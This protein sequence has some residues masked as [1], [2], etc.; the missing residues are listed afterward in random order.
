MNENNI[1][2]NNIL[3]L[4]AKRPILIP[5]SNI[6]PSVDKLRLSTN[7]I[8]KNNESKTVPNSPLLSI[9][10][11]L[12]KSPSIPVMIVDKFDTKEVIET[13][14]ACRPEGEK[15]RPMSPVPIKL[16]KSRENSPDSKNSLLHNNILSDVLLHEIHNIT[17]TNIVT[18]SP[19]TSPTL[20]IRAISPYTLLSPESKKN[21]DNLVER[22][23]KTN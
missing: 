22:I 2:Q 21:F 1:K 23:C 7:N 6:L 5:I 11:K 8:T 15:I 19:I 9:P 3:H 17:G 13:S 16:D 14:F 12:I 20:D 18:S 10:E 4:H